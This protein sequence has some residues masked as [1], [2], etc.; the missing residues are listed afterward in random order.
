V[1]NGQPWQRI[2]V[3]LVGVP[4]GGARHPEPID[5]AGLVDVGDVGHVSPVRVPILLEDVRLGTPE[6]SPERREFRRPEAL[7]AKHH[8]RMLGERSVDPLERGDVEGAR[9][10]DADDFGAQGFAERSQR[11]CDTHGSLGP[12]SRPTTTKGYFVADSIC[13]IGRCRTQAQVGMV[14]DSASR[15][16]RRGD[17]IAENSRSRL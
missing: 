3:R 5:S 13:G 4:R 2:L 7:I 16:W 15:N 11:Q 17:R 8:H 6:L 10:V 9:H 14:P 12:S 1:E